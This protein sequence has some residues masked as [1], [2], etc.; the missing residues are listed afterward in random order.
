[1]EIFIKSLKHALTITGFVFAMM[2]LIDYINVFS[3]G[4]LDDIVKKKRGFQYIITSFLGAT[5]GCLGAFMDVSFYIHGVISF[6]A[7]AGG[8]IATSGDEAFV[9]LARFPKTAILIFGILFILGVFSAFIIDKIAPVLGLQTGPLEC[10]LYDNITSQ[11]ECRPLG[12]KEIKREFK[13]IT[14]SRFLLLVLIFIFIYGFST[15]IIGPARWNW[16]RITAMILLG[17]SLFIV[18]TVG[19]VY[20]EEH[21]WKHIFKEHTGTIFL[22]SFGILLILNFGLEFW[23]LEAFVKN[24]MVWVLLISVLVGLIPESGPHLVFV[25]L[26][27]KGMIPISVLLAGSIVQDGHG[28]LPLVSYSVKDAV[29]V[30]SINFIIGLSVGTALYLLGL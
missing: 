4:R 28:M 18:V 13:N 8:M 17:I 29:K 24:H 11:C 14:L 12:F 10:K 20:L 7:L 19:Q 30:K 25:M 6:G 22:W 16:L 27:S 15:G 5:P 1:M 9:M 2:L 3:R 26:F 23:N 21:I